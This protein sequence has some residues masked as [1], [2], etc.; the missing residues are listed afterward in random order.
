MSYPSRAAL[1]GARTAFVDMFLVNSTVES[2][3][4]HRR[5]GPLG[6]QAKA[7]LRHAQRSTQ[8]PSVVTIWYTATT[9]SQPSKYEVN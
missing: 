4:E 7:L 3:S 9:N 8:V 5:W 1:G 6:N 2:G